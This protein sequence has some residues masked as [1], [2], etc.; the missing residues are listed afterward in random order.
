[1]N[2]ELKPNQRVLVTGK[3]G[4]GKSYFVIHALVP[5]FRYYVMYDYKH[6]IDLP[7]AVVF[8]KIRD[9]SDN[10][11]QPKVIYRP[12]KGTDEEFNQLC[13]VVFKRGNTMFVVD[14]IVN[15]CTQSYIQPNHALILR[16]GRSKGVGN[17]NCTQE[18]VGVHRNLLTQAEHYFIFDIPDPNHRKKLAGYTGPEV[19]ERIQNYWFWYYAP[20]MQDPV[21]MQ[22][23]KI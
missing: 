23:L 18:P 13:G 5:M 6:E 2:I 16:L 17:I 8:N 21:L 11:G 4:C 20:G 14:E 15:H 10:P 9:F 3:T 1:M 19:M 12:E 22:P 7:G